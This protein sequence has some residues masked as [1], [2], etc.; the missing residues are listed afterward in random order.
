[1]LNFSKITP[2]YNK[3]K[4]AIKNP[5]PDNIKKLQWGDY[6]LGLD[7][8][9]ALK[10][11]DYTVTT[12]YHGKFNKNKDA[13]INIVIR[14]LD[15]L[16]KIRYGKTN[17]LY[18]I[19]HPE[20]IKKKELNKYDIIISASEAFCQKL[21]KQGY[22]AFYLPQFTNAER[23][24]HKDDTEYKN[25]ILFVGAPHMGMRNSVYY[26]LKNNLP[27][28]IYG[29]SWDKYIDKS[30]I[31]GNLINNTELYKYYSNADIVL[32]D[33]MQ[34]MKDNGFISNRIYDVTACKGFIISDYMPEIEKIYGDAIPMYKNEKEF[35][36][37]I[38]YYLEH[39]KERNEK[40]EKAY[41]ITIEKYTNKYFANKLKN[42]IDNYKRSTK[43][44]VRFFIYRLFSLSK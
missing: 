39:P 13:D 35:V 41:K 10:E 20:K 8:A 19:S 40:A 38:N 31:K 29:H 21:Q 34:A 7:L 26:A 11:Y 36:Q 33:H 24:C 37:L 5:S 42:I 23:F 18:I 2:I 4:I 9:A 25:K 22:N 16:K 30:Y 15:E 3:I 44:K 17:I 12:D 43:T 6:W 32:N 27:I 28:S 14:G 1:M